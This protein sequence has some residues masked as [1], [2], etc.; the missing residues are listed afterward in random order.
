MKKKKNPNQKHL[1]TNIQMWHICRNSSLKGLKKMWKKEKMLVTSIFSFFYIFF[2][3]VLFLKVVKIWVCVAKGEHTIQCKTAHISV[4]S[5]HSRRLWHNQP[6]MFIA[7]VFLLFGISDAATTQHPSQACC[8]AHKFTATMLE[9]GANLQPNSTNPEFRQVSDDE[10]W[11]P[12]INEALSLTRGHDGPESLTW[13]MVTAILLLI[14]FLSTLWYYGYNSMSLSRGPIDNAT[15]RAVYESFKIFK[16]FPLY[17]CIKSMTQ[18]QMVN[19][20]TRAII[21]SISEEIHEMMLHAN[22]KAAALRIL[23]MKI[24]KDFLLYLYVKSPQY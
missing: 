15:C 2:S 11:F 3:K 7:F 22:M 6:T 24:F 18:Q 23:D 4:R 8:V 21:W 1:Q 16:D 14:G 12:S 13:A 20:H 19:A 10:Y 5:L 9:L 17:V